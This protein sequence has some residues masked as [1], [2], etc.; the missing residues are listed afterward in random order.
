MPTTRTGALV[1]KDTE[2]QSKVTATNT[3][4]VRMNQMKNEMSNLQTKLECTIS[5]LRGTFTDYRDTKEVVGAEEERDSSVV[6]IQ[7][8]WP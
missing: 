6:I 4:I 3:K 5:R 1:E 8:K 2:E 7:K